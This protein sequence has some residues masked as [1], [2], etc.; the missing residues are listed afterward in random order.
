MEDSKNAFRDFLWHLAGYKKEIIRQNRV[1]GYHA[2]IIGTLLLIVGVYATLAWTFF[3]QTVSQ[4]IIIALVAGLFMGAFIVSFDRALIASLS[5]G[6]PNIYS[7]IFRFILATLLGIFLAQPMILKF[8][9]SDIS[10]EAQ[11][12]VDKKNQER[13]AE[14]EALYANDMMQLRSEKEALQK[15]I[16]DKREVVL[17]AEQDFKSEMD[18]SGGTGHWG[19]HIVSRQKQKILEQ[20]QNEYDK[21]YAVNVP[22]IDTL[23]HQMDAITQKIS[24]DFEAFKTG[25]T[26]YGILIQA[27]A[28]QSLLSKDATGTL[29]M[30]YY[31]LSFILM[32]IELS[33]LIA[34]LLFNTRGYKGRVEGIT[35]EE[36]VRNAYEQEIVLAKLEAFKNES[37]TYGTEVLQRFFKE[38][39]DAQQQ[40]L[41][42]FMQ[43]NK[44]MTAKE[45]Y[46]AFQKRFGFTG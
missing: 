9:Q 29:R 15:Q 36:V 25:N 11:I 42:A 23:Q 27:E 28:L 16:E 2:A 20:H 8:Y 5:T 35:E 33:A 38:N 30:R 1:D 40:K 19:Y 18:G 31:L 24:N 14:L 10:R 45:L 4:N 41:Q 32:L 7:L 22:K 34:K 13:K 39:N 6:K 46:A 3:F 26:E 43:E 21:L 17:Q 44:D 12:L 37:L